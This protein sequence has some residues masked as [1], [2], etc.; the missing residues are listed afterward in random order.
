MATPSLYA[1]LAG[2]QALVE[3][4]KSEAWYLFDADKKKVAG[5]VTEK[6]K[7][8]QSKVVARAGAKGKL[9]KGWKIF[10]VPPKTVV[11]TC[12]IG[13]VVCPGVNV[14]NPTT[15]FF[16]LVRFGK[17]KTSEGEGRCRR[18]EATTSSSPVPARTSTRR[19]A[20]RS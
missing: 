16:Y 18:C 15:N 9:P 8:L 14:E 1:L 5:P 4:G 2:Q 11:L 12:G 13:E 19:R 3:E 10:G 17:F 6:D 7:L 20:S